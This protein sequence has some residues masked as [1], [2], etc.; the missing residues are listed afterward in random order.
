MV[1]RRSVNLKRHPN[2]GHPKP[3]TIVRSSAISASFNGLE[4][5]RDDPTGFPKIAIIPFIGLP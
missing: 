5:G 4:G 3:S 2:D 1:Y